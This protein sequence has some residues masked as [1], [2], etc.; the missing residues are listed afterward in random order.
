MKIGTKLPPLSQLRTDAPVSAPTAAKVNAALDRLGAKALEAL[1]AKLTDGFDGAGSIVPRSKDQAA[2]E[3]SE[4]LRGAPIGQKQNA[5]NGGNTLDRAPESV[6][7]RDDVNVNSARHTEATRQVKAN[8][9]LED[10][11]LD[12][13]S[14]KQRAEYETVK[15]VCEKANDPVAQLSLQKLLLEG[16]L[17]GEKDLK[18]SG[19]V[20]DN[21]SKLATSTTLAKGIDRAQLL[22]DV[23]QE[24]AT[25]SAISQGGIGS[26]APTTIAVQLAMTKPAEYVR[27]INGIADQK[28]RVEMASGM[29]LAREKGTRTDDGTG[30]ATSQRLLGSALMEIAN[31][32]R[33]FDNANPSAGEGAWADELDVLYD[34]VMGKQMSYVKTDTPAQQAAAIDSIKNQLEGGLSVSVA[35]HWDGGGHKLLITGRA[36]VDG[37]PGF[38]LN[39]PWGREERITESDLQ[40]RL[41]DVNKDPAIERSGMFKRLLR[42]AMKD[43]ER[44]PA[45][46]DRNTDAFIG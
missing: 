38:T 9:K 46:L 4:F 26:C 7:S 17:P 32:K 34:N 40:K 24:L 12:K 16:S 14:A 8:E 23:V 42:D 3:A 11:A 5:G 35:V 1:K 27:L 25:P 37:Q 13:L 33:L 44:T 10:A 29:V 31:G 45:V 39:N 22:T 15:K 36:E 20:L 19:N 18:G 21:L 30:R 6:N 2:K 41:I 43:L 28:A